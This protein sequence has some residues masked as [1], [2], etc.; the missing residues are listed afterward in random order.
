MR[1]LFGGRAGG[2]GGRQTHLARSFCPSLWAPFQDGSG[3]GAPR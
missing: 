2:G 1:V 3:M